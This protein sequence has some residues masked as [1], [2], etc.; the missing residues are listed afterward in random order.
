MPRVKKD[1]AARP[2]VALGIPARVVDVLLD[3]LGIDEEEI[4]LD[5]T[6]MDDLKGDSLDIVEL[7]MA[8]EEEFGI[9]ISDTVTE[10][11]DTGTVQD[12]LDD[13]RRLGVKVN[14]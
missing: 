9:A 12:V 8:F 13:L 11:W 4:T 1:P 3:V 5:A 7:A 14:A 2:A 10:R 6:L